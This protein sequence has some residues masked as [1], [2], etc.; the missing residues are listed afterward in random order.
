MTA[1]KIAPM[2][3]QRDE[4][5]RGWVLYD[6]DCPLCLATVA[7]FTPLLLRH[8]FQIAP[9][10]TPWVQERLGLLPSTPLD[11]MKLLIDDGQIYGGADALLQMA[12][13]IWWAWPL[14]ALACLAPREC[15][16]AR[17]AMRSTSWPA[18]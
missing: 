8:R 14:F 2:K 7:R 11:E 17:G 15:R 12:R 9:L 16:A 1:A 4:P 18:K 6:G 3:A 13:G 10:Q 5:V